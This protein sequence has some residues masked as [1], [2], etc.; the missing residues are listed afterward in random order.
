MNDGNW[1]TEGGTSAGTSATLAKGLNI[2]NVLAAAGRPVRMKE[3]IA[4][5][6]LTRPTLHRLLQTL[7]DEGFVMHQ[8]EERNYTVGMHLL[9]MAHQVWDGLDI[10]QTAAVEMELLRNE[11]HEAAQLS[12]R[13]G[14]F[15]VHVD[16]LESLYDVRTSSQ[17]GQRVALG[18]S[19]MGLAVAAFSSPAER[20][21]LI[22]AERSRGGQAA[23]RQFRLQ[24]D[25]VRVRGYAVHIGDGADAVCGI[26][27]PIMD[28]RGRAA[29]ALGIVGPAFR[30]AE[31]ELHELGPAVLESARRISERVGGQSRIVLNTP[32]PQA[33]SPGVWS[34]SDSPDLIGDSPVWQARRQRLYWLDT[35]GPALCWANPGKS[36]SHKTR[37]PL[38]EVTTGLAIASDGRLLLNGNSGYQLFDPDT[39]QS[40]RLAH[41]MMAES[42]LRYN[43][44][45]CDAAG[46]F[47]VGTM[48]IDGPTR[49]G[50]HLYRLNPDRTIK[51]YAVEG[52]AHGNGIGW[53][54][55]NRVMY[56]ADS[57]GRVVNAFDYDL[58]RG[59]IS[60]MRPFLRLSGPGSDSPAGLAVDRDGN[61]WVTMWDGWRLQCHAPD[62]ALRDVV[63]LPVP[64]PSSCVFGGEDMRTLFVT[65][66]RIRVS[67]RVLEQA[68]QSG[69][70][71]AFQTKVPGLPVAKF[72]VLGSA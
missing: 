45:G 20:E 32:P 6:G 62:G 14:D 17:L 30:M 15:V 49:G 16:E 11:Y 8:R 53:S 66:A 22:V 50:G 60:N 41:I 26:A 18:H 23:A 63:W 10:R 61:V 21:R 34:I 31:N 39:A 38:S 54:P 72:A 51:H 48:H 37:I 28:H 35:G 4:A 40:E 52:H 5:T 36:D 46:R 7:V 24:L 59:E 1:E 33:A 57:G 44:G 19:P 56:I 12:V 3:L 65:S 68:P 27:A 13:D 70:T 29:F 64:R 69:F 9:E 71:L 2:L 55:D 67:H 25:L 58:E 47:W 43:G 42:E